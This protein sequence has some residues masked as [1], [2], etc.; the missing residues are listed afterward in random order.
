MTKK[1]LMMPDYRD[2]NPYQL[3][4]AQALRSPELKPVFSQGYRRILPL[5][6]AC[7]DNSANVLHLH[8]LT[9]YLR[10]KSWLVS[11][12]YSCKLLVD[13]GLIRLQKITIIWT[14]HNHLTHD[15]QYPKLEAWLRKNLFKLADE[16]IVHN[17]ASIERLQLL[18]PDLNL[19]LDRHHKLNVIP[20]G[21]YRQIYQPAID[22]ATARAKLNLPQHGYLYL[23]LGMIRPYK[24]IEN[25]LQAW[26]ASSKLAQN[27][28]LLVAGKYLDSAYGKKI[29]ALTGAT[30]GV[31]F[32]PQFIPAEEMHL[33][34]SAADVVVLPFTSILT[35]GSLILAMSYNKPIVAPNQGGIKEIL[36]TANSLLYDSGDRLGLSKALQ[37]S[38]QID[39]R[40]LSARVSQISDRLNWHEIAQATAKLYR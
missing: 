3:L 21:N 18:H 4:L 29:T 15:C 7:Q 16:I 33:Y 20:H 6:R 14:V 26:Q 9:P 34:F 2:H 38:T 27:H 10:G 40:Q 22:R 30:K 37:V 1:I 25:L 35:S 31:I 13:L 24:G 32:Q 8:W 17:H 5:Y 12:I 23:N 39:L 36:E 11:L 28:T 19:D